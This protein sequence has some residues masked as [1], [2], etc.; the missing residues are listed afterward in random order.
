M[1]T[2]RACRLDRHCQEELGEALRDRYGDPAVVRLPR[3]LEELMDELRDCGP[4]ETAT[5]N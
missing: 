4:R 2:E 1:E 5:K 3:G